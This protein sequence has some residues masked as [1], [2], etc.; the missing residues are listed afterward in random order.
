MEKI[1]VIDNYDSFTYNLV[2]YIESNENFEIDVFR[3]DE[4]TIETAGKYNIIILSP[5]PGLPK[6]AGILK[7][8]IKTYASTKKIL[9]VCLGMQAIGEVYG[10][11]L[12]NLDTV[13]HGEATVLKVLDKND[14]LFKNLPSTF[15]VGR[16][17]SWIIDNKN[18]PKDLLIS[19]TDENG[20]IMSLKH[21]DYQLYGV[22][23]HPE[24]ILT[25]HGKEIISNFLSK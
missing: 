1:L 18:F 12:I 7:E 6:N 23:F 21:K 16:Y 17:H 15:N 10:G 24:S 2:H 8:L 14:L 5:G 9:G 11:T 4:I 22:Q 3:N 13:I 19:S 20:Q 25:E